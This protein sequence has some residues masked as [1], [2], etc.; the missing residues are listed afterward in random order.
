[1]SLNITSFDTSFAYNGSSGGYLSVISAVHDRHTVVSSDR[2]QLRFSL[3]L[4]IQNN[5]LSDRQIT[6]VSALTN[7]FKILSS[8][9]PSLPAII[10][11]E[12]G[13]SFTVIIQYENNI[14]YSGPLDVQISTV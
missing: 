7:G 12:G 1:M 6:S 10:P 14:D 13:L 3:S 5:G 11:R 2:S 9:I 4:I 8:N